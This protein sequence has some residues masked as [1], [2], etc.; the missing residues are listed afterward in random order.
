MRSD[1]EKVLVAK[2]FK[3]TGP[4]DSLDM[5]TFPEKRGANLTLTPT[6]ELT[7][8]GRLTRQTLGMGGLVP[9]KDEGILSVGGWV[10]LIMLEP[11]SGE[12]MWIKRVEVQSVQEPYVV[13]YTILVRQGQRVQNILSDT[14]PSAYTT[15]LNRIYPKIMEGAWTYFHPD[16]VVLTKRQADEVR[17]RKR[18]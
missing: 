5:M 17:E 3:V 10:S 13:S 4:F 9:N 18:Y 2:G 12:K 1:L 7:M 15:A 8:D 6:V 14:R 11:L 16:E